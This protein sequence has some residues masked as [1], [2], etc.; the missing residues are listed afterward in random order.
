MKIANQQDIDSFMAFA[1]ND[2]KMLPYLSMSRWIK[3]RKASDSDWECLHITDDRLSYL[4]TINFNRNIS[5]SIT[6]ALYAKSKIAAGRAIL[7]IKEVVKRYKPFAIDSCV[8]ESNKE[9]F[10]IT[11]K[12]LGEPWGKEP[13]GAWNLAEGIF[14]DVYCFRKIL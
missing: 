13:M 8:A 9:S 3:P 2:P 10:E 6:I 11:K 5:L 7:N 12:I 4:L 1:I 14:E